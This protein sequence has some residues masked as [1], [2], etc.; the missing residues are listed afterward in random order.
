[1][2]VQ[3]ERWV[4]KVDDYHRMV[5]TGILSEDSR[6]ELLEGEIVKMSPVGSR[7]VACVNR[8]NGLL[9]RKLGEEV[10]IS[11]QNPFRLNDYSEPEPDIAL[12]KGR[13][14][15][16]AD[17][18]AAPADVLLLVEVA[19]TSI[20][21]DR[22]VKLPMYA[23]AG[24]SEVW[25]V[26]LMEDRI[27]TYTNPVNESYQKVRIARRGESLLSEGLANL[28]LSVDEILG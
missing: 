13:D 18:L 21:I 28:A 7:H 15:F 23:R 2:S 17:A 6:V 11:I 26:N 4:F 8:L 3:L 25:L 1:M 16:Y 22:R 12:L 24:I 20:E 10:I 9:S 27:E 19:N 5:E 14:D